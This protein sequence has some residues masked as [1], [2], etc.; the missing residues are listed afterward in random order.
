MDREDSDIVRRELLSQG[1]RDRVG[2]G[3]GRGI[4]HDVR[5]GAPKGR[6]R[7]VAGQE[8]TGQK[9]SVGKRHTLAGQGEY[10]NESTEPP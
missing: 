4:S 6:H 2:R 10:R 8:T 1:L 9:E 3:L 7:V 5:A